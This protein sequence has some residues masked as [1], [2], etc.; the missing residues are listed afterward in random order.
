M[1][2]TTPVPPVQHQPTISIE[3]LLWEY[4]AIEHHRKETL[5]GQSS[6]TVTILVPKELPSVVLCTRLVPI[7]N[8]ANL[9]SIKLPEGIYSCTDRLVLEK[10]KVRTPIKLRGW[11]K[12]SQKVCISAHCTCYAPKLHLTEATLDLIKMCEQAW[13]DAGSQYGGIIATED[14]RQHNS[15]LVSRAVG[16][17]SERNAILRFRLSSTS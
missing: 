15:Q 4:P 3:H 2:P 1:G 16:K 10:L 5:A 8:T 13:W 6:T 7:Q 17:W 9:Y 11:L 12:S 14:P